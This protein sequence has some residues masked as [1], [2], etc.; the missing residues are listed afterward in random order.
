MVQYLKKVASLPT[1]VGRLL[2]IAYSQRDRPRFLTDKDIEIR[3]VSI[4][5]E[6]IL[7]HPDQWEKV[8]LAA[9]ERMRKTLES[10]DPKP[11]AS[12]HLRQ[13]SFKAQ[14][15]CELSLVLHF[16]SK[17]V[18]DTSPP[19]PYIGLSKPPCSVCW[20]FFYKLWGRR[21]WLF[22]TRT[23]NGKTPFSWN[24]PDS[25]L[26]RSLYRRSFATIYQKLHADLADRYA[27]YILSRRPRHFMSQETFQEYYWELFGELPKVMPRTEYNV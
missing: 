3:H 11:A 15:H 19:L 24:F 2:D 26:A 23:T 17:D 1:A 21:P 22:F 14:V 10:S 7:S 25:E 20:N 8:A 12:N 4:V 13:Q 18:E 6:I 5:G 9:L 16:L 27:K